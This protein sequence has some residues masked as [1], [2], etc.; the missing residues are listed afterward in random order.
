MSKNPVDSALEKQLDYLKLAYLKENC[1]PFAAEANAKHWSY[2]D[3]HPSS[4]RKPMSSSWVTVG[5]GSPT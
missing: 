4:T 1:R 3:Y 5:L 2:L